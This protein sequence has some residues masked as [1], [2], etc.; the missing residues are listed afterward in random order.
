MEIVS[1]LV[2]VVIVLL[3]LN[4]MAGGKPNSVLRPVQRILTRLIGSAIGLIAT[5]F[6]AGLKLLGG[7][8]KSIPPPGRKHEGG[9]SEKPPPRW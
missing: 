6:A 1:S 8:V 2:L 5:F 7:S 3:A 9:T 4:H